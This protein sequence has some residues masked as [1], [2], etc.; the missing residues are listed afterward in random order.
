MVKKEHKGEGEISLGQFNEYMTEPLQCLLEEVLAQ[1]AETFAPE[2]LYYEDEYVE[3]ACHYSE[4]TYR[5]VDAHRML[6]PL[7]RS[8]IDRIDLEKAALHIIT[9]TMLPAKISA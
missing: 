2:F 1:L 3:A 7:F 6:A 9:Q 8:A 5:E 4:K